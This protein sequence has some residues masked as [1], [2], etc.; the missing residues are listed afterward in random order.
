MARNPEH[1]LAI[2]PKGG[3]IEFERKHEHANTDTAAV[4]LARRAGEF[5][6]L[7]KISL[8]IGGAEVAGSTAVFLVTDL[9]Q[10]YPGFLAGIIGGGIS[11]GAY[12]YYE[13]KRS[14]LESQISQLNSPDRLPKINS[15][16]PPRLIKR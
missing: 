4:H 15:P 11:F 1:V 2:T 9:V 3:V 16:I 12:R 7:S 14:N 13:N 5:D 10:R 6:A 8:I